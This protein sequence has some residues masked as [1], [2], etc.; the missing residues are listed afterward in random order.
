MKKELIKSSLLYLNE[1]NTFNYNPNV[2][3]RVMS[4]QHIKKRHV[5]FNA[6]C[7]S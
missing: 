1:I 3:L 6:L 2:I 5:S 7:L 4:K